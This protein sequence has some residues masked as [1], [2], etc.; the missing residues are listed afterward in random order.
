MVRYRLS[1][2]R[3]AVYRVVRCD[4]TR[5]AGG[6]AG[7][8]GERG[9]RG[10]AGW[11][12]ER[13]VRDWAGSL[14][15]HGFVEWT[16]EFRAVRSA[17]VALML[18]AVT[19]LA[20]GFTLAY[21]TGALEELPGLLLLVPAAIAVKGNIFGALGSRLG[22]ALHTGTLR[23]GGGPDSVIVQNTLAAATLSLSSGVV[24]AI[25]AK[26]VA[27]VFSVSPTMTVADFVVVST[28]G[29]IMASVAVLAITLAATAAAVRFGWDL[30]NVVAPLVTATADVVSLPALVLAAELA[31][32]SVFTPAAAW[33]LAGWSALATVWALRSRFADVRRIV[34]ESMPVLTAAGLL[35]LV[36]G[37]TVEKRLDNFVAL[38][39]LLVLLPGYLGTAGAL[40][41]VLSSR[42]S[43]K[44]HLGMVRPSAFP[45]KPVRSDMAMMFVL[46]LPV[47]AVLGLLASGIG[48]LVGLAGPGHPRLL[49]VAVLGGLMV[50]V[51]VGVVAYYGTL[52]A[53]RLGL[54]PD[55]CGIPM[56]TSSLDF[57]G[58]FTLILAIVTVGA[59]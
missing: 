44:L 45:Q 26:G 19:S 54:D 46:S 40:G 17:F 1:Q 30:D 29:G 56:V 10:K 4:L 11:R 12:G 28:V 15:N 58:A 43:T 18:A 14:S 36:A 53:V 59:G 6:K 2:I 37:I 27:L 42:L 24:L 52:T 51:M 35:D 31:G 16:R 8:R 48:S 33:A 32:I 50:T 38:P 23:F 20:A 57:V 22:T 34:R 41:G 7:W 5:A 55:T 13:D 9:V 25:L 3:V 39:V 49:G 47:F 21:A